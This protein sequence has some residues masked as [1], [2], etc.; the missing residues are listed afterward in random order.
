LKK[1][2]LRSDLINVYKDVMA[3]CQEGGARLFSVASNDR[4]RG[5]D[6]KLECRR[7]H[8]NLRKNFFAVRVAEHWNTLPRG[9]G[10]VSFSGDI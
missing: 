2:R 10:G 5:K 6:C 3:E 9:A 4:T 1:R 8:I 7:F